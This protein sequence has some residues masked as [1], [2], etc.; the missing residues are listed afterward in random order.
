MRSSFVSMAVMRASSS[1]VVGPRARGFVT[2]SP[3]GRWCGCA[4]ARM[5]PTHRRRVWRP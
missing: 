1:A 2:Q 4:G 5:C 3:A